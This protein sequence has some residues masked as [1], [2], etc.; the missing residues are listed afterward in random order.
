MTVMAASKN[1]TPGQRQTRSRQGS[2]VSWANTTD[3]TARTEPGRQGMRRKFEDEVDPERTLRPEE[4]AKRAESAR[5]AYFTRL[6]Y[7]AV[8]PRFTDER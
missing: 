1:L 7:M 8:K 5:K 6:S 4:R 2:H 3:R